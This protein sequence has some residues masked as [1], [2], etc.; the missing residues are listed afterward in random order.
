MKMNIIIVCVFV[1]QFT[2]SIYIVI[3]QNCQIVKPKFTIFGRW[4]YERKKMVIAYSPNHH[5]WT[6]IY[7]SLKE[8]SNHSMRLARFWMNH[9]KPAFINPITLD[10]ENNKQLEFGSC[11]TESNDTEALWTRCSRKREIEWMRLR[12]H[13]Y[14]ASFDFNRI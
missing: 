3:D 6:A 1:S 4:V 11:E 5:Q 10:V 7:Q 14:E 12:S 9:E 8:E 2:S 13:F